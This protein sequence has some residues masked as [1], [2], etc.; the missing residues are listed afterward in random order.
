[1]VGNSWVDL[2]MRNM[3]MRWDSYWWVHWRRIAAVVNILQ[4]DTHGCR[5]SEIHLMCL[6]WSY[7]MMLY[8]I[9]KNNLRLPT[10]MLFLLVSIKLCVSLSALQTPGALQGVAYQRL[11]PTGQ[12]MLPWLCLCQSF[13]YSSHLTQSDLHSNIWCVVKALGDQSQTRST[14]P[15]GEGLW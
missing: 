10:P 9:S 1:M 13:G 4:S 11:S 6:L 8:M 7:V 3:P 2:L 5:N 15:R 14:F 12:C